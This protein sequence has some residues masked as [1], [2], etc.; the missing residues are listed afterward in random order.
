M[1]NQF[2]RSLSS[3]TFGGGCA[4]QVKLGLA[5]GATILLMM[6]GANATTVIVTPPSLS[7]TSITGAVISCGPCGGA[8]SASAAQ[9]SVPLAQFGTNYNI[10]SFTPSLQQSN[11]NTPGQLTVT[12]GGATSTLS[13]TGGADPSFTATVSGSTVVPGTSYTTG[14]VQTGNSFNYYFEVVN[15]NNPSSTASATVYVTASGGASVSSELLNGSPGTATAIAQLTINSPTTFS[16]IAQSTTST[17]SVFNVSN[18]AVA[19]QLDQ[20]YEV[21]MSVS[22]NG[23]NAINGTAYV[24]PT[25]VSPGNDIFFSSGIQSAVPEPS[26]WAMMLLGFAG[27][28]FMA[29]RRKSKSALMAA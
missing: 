26:T 7:P 4:M 20:V 24:D 17:P 23:G 19:I 21:T 12:V 13:A 5:V 27:L 1:T 6:T 10:T 18:D 2:Y 28:G 29:Y 8:F 11:V 25:I 16:E 15:P 3:A 9:G 22:V 14:A